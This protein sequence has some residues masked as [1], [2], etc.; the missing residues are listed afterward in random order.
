MEIKAGNITI[1][2][3][4]AKIIEEC[5]KRLLLN[6]DEI[7]I[8]VNTVLEVLAGVDYEVKYTKGLWKSNPNNYPIIDKWNKRLINKQLD[9]DRKW[10][11]EIIQEYRNLFE[12]M[13]WK[14]QGG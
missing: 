14:K 2:I 5:D 9:E 10:S 6:P 13:G 8:V 3:D 12:E 11:E 4:A 7:A 1:N